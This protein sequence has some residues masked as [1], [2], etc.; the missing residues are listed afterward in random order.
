MI[1]MVN[2]K[3]MG[4]ILKDREIDLLH[5]LY[6]QKYLTS[7][8]MQAYLRIPEGGPY[9]N[10]VTRLGKFSRYGLLDRHERALGNK[11]FRFYYYRIGSEGLKVLKRQ[12]RIS[13]SDQ[14]KMP[15]LATRNLE[16]FLATQEVVLQATLSIGEE[17]LQSIA[18][19]ECKHLIDPKDELEKPIIVPD[20]IIK[21]KSSPYVYIEMDT[22]SEQLSDLKE[23]LSRYKKLAN[24]QSNMAHT[25][26]LVSL[27]DSF[28][29]R[30]F[31][32]DKLRRTANMKQKLL[33]EQI[34]DLSNLEVYVIPLRRS[35]QVI[36]KILD[37]E[38]S[39]N[40]EDYKIDCE[41]AIQL[42]SDFNKRFRFTFSPL[43]DDEFYYKDIEERYKA[44]LICEVRNEEGVTLENVAI[45]YMR[46]GFLFSLDRLDYLSHL[47]KA[48]KTKQLID[49]VIAIYHN[50]DELVEDV[51]GIE[52][53]NVLIGDA[54]SWATPVN[55]IPEFYGTVSPFKKEVVA[56]VK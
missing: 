2:R 49:R 54:E 33:E 21:G 23:K 1:K 36:Q 9:Q 45:I 37:E 16:H 39:Y 32:G 55:G 46:E 28:S 8:Q 56:Y 31:F 44:D 11:G 26:L 5:F 18:P 47:I 27:D 15:K 4:I 35:S 14:N 38:K 6:K 41:V 7:K 34:G 29:T 19:F 40:P 30:H 53:D 17:N 22:G 3:R 12:R 42:I 25:L 13:S 43:D 52:Y 20:W 10:F 51:W 24:I 50:H 48:Q